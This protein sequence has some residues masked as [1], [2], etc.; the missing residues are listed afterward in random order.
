MD[1][2]VSG[3]PGAR[4]IGALEWQGRTY[5]CVLGRT[6]ISATKREGDGVTPVGRFVLKD[7]L[8]RADRV[9]PPKTGLPVRAL[10]P[11][12]GWCDDPLDGLYNCAV[13]HPYP[14]SAEQLWRNDGLYDVIVVI[15]HNAAPVT[16]GAGSA[17]FIHVADPDN[18]PTEGCIALPRVD[19][20]DI[21]TKC[22]PDTHVQI[23]S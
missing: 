19:L 17:I 10:E 4:H 6:G 23:A 3:A 2:N 18:G 11:D 14:A 1:I 16:P 5:P 12:D 20:L 13:K 22:T 21:L 7:V 9:S 15:G 8:F